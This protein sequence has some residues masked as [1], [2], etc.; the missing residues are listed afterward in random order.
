MF[1]QFLRVIL[2]VGVLV[3]GGVLAEKIISDTMRKARNI[4]DGW[5][6]K[7]CVPDD[8]EMHARGTA[9]RAYKKILDGEPPVFVTKEFQW[10]VAEHEKAGWCFVKF[11]TV[12]KTAYVYPQD[13]IHN[14]KEKKKVE[15]DDW[16]SWSG[17]MK[18]PII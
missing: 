11:D 8:D 7:S 3:G 6:I 2:K 16:Q 9:A 15:D 17:K 10:F 18:N 14:Y 13:K 5:A 4:V 12:T 1:V